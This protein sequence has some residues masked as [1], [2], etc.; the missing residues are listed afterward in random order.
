MHT[1]L[2]FNSTQEENGCINFLDLTITRKTSHLET[3][4]YRKPTTTDTNVHSTSIHPNEHKLAAYR[5]YIEW[6]LNRVS[7]L[8]AEAVGSPDTILAQPHP[9]SNT[10]QSKNNTANVVVQQH[11]RKLLKMDILMT[12]T[13]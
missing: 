1:N 4:I 10:Q 5:Y 12:E 9:I 11:S 2:Q 3:D 8:L 13:C 7:G 6:M